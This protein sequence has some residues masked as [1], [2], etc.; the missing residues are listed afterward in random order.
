MK[1]RKPTSNAAELKACA[2]A[3]RRELR[4]AQRVLHDAEAATRDLEQSVDDLMLGQASTTKDTAASLGQL[5]QRLKQ[6]VDERVV[7]AAKTLSRKKKRLSKFTVT[8][9]GRTMAGKSTLREAI[10]GGDGSSIGKG[11]QRTTRDLREY[12]WQ[13]LH[14]VDTPGIA[15]YRGKHDQ[16]L[17]VS[18]LDETDLV[19][20]LTSSDGVQ[21][22]AFKGLAKLREQNKP[23]VFVLN[24]KRDLTKPV[25]MQRF[26]RD[27]AT[28]FGGEFVDGHRNRIGFLAGQCLG[29]PCPEIVPIHAQAA[30]LATRPAH[31]GHAVALRRA[32][33]MEELLA[34]ILDQLKTR[35]TVLR[36]RTIIDG[37]W[38]ALS[39]LSVLME[40]ETNALTEASTRITQKWN[41]FDEWL[42]KLLDGMKS[43]LEAN[44]AETV[45]PLRGSISRFVEDNIERSDV[46]DRWAIH[47]KDFGLPAKLQDFRN[48]V[49]GEITERLDELG[50]DYET[51][52]SILQDF[53]VPGPEACDPADYRKW[54][55][56]TSAAS[57]AL[58][59]VAAVGAWVGSTN[60]WNP[61][62][63]VAGAVSL[64]AFG[65][66]W[67]FRKR[68]KR[69][70]EGR[71]AATDNLQQQ[72]D[73]LASRVMA[74]QEQ[75][76]AD[77]LRKGILDGA[78]RSTTALL[79][80]M[81]GLAKELQQT[82]ARIDAALDDLA[83]R[84][85]SQCSRSLGLEFQLADLIAVRRAPGLITVA[86]TQNGQDG[87]AHGRRLSDALGEVVAV[88]HDGP[89][90]AMVA[91][92][93]A[94]FGVQ[95]DMVHASTTGVTVQPRTAPSDPCFAKLVDAARVVATAL[96]C[97]ID[98]AEG[99]NDGTP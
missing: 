59:G 52:T 64:V 96:N 34:A 81:N 12:R 9:F 43:R 39:P 51:D 94:A 19:L 41:E 18:I 79:D 2:R 71:R 90:E 84:L 87:D 29:M 76:V 50:R 8:L 78:K 54:L 93:L 53:A 60:F 99:S 55:R 47:V 6:L 72:V 26:L 80:A 46:K 85:V 24:M 68:E 40:A 35:G 10:T 33:R 3:A 31:S 37:T 67:F 61:V 56:R 42:S 65:L 74:E 63:W 23:V 70:A 49:L 75:W 82:R 98:V 20:F 5:K 77:E 73:E 92:A 89:R 13:G 14:L 58:A 57:A 25:F 16:E 95:P 28:V 1:L 22:D 97:A 69:L 62:G 66:S 86:V 21:E 4:F 7:E 32:S 88:L 83:A 17:A 44:V 11:G 30:F 15:A 91:H 27:P 45:A 36:I 48:R 38:H